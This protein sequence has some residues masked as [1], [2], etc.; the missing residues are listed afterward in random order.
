MFDHSYQLAVFICIYDFCILLLYFTISLYSM[1]QCFIPFYL[2]STFHPSELSAFWGPK[3]WDGPVFKDFEASTERSARGRVGL[4]WLGNVAMIGDF[5]AIP[6]DVNGRTNSSHLRT[7][8][9]VATLHRSDNDFSIVLPWF[10][11]DVN[12][13]HPS[14]CTGEMNVGQSSLPSKHKVQEKQ[15]LEGDVWFLL[16]SELNLLWNVFGSIIWGDW[17]FV[18]MGESWHFLHDRPNPKSTLETWVLSCLSCLLCLSHLGLGMS[19]KTFG[20]GEIWMWM[21]HGDLSPLSPL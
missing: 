14:C 6:V 20:V 15:F 2:S 1:L 12:N 5:S 16:I 18:V 11:H 9:L 10:S 7:P 19:P 4:S 8:S 13:S 3:P 21:N 17:W